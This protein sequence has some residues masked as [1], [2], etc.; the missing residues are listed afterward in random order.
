M[1]SKI[2]IFN[3]ALSHIGVTSTVADELERSVERVTCS[4]FWDT[5]RD[6]L[7]S[8]KDM[9][10]SFARARVALADIGSPP[11]GWGYQY[12]YPNDCI[13]ALAIDFPGMRY[14]DDRYRIPFQVVYEASGRAIL[15][16]Q[17]EASLIYV[18]RIEEVER[19]PSYFVEAMAL[20][21]AA[22]IAMP[23]AKGMDIRGQLM[24][25]AEQAI[26]VAMAAS[27]NEQ[28]PDRAGESVYIQEIHA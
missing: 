16:D 4:R 27:L 24:Q 15:T 11:E 23:L 17:E 1:A 13:N 12:R 19:Y 18:K 6:A 8:Y 22:F 2:D 10:W 26:Q 28:Q 7:L 21:L 3:M 9:D 5:C 20:R 25:E 14:P